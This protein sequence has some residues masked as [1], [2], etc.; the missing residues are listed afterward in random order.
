[1]AAHRATVGYE[2]QEDEEEEGPIRLQVQAG[3]EGRNGDCL[4]CVMSTSQLLIQ[5]Q[6][7]EH[8]FTPQYSQN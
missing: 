5:K 7:E 1:M 4:F 8:I 2:Q 3:G 6:E